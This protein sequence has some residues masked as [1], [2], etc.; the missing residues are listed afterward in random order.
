MAK[1]LFKVKSNTT[2]FHWEGQ[3]SKFGRK[4]KYFSSA[5]EAARGLHYTQ[6]RP[7]LGTTYKSYTDFINDLV[8]EELHPDYYTKIQSFPATDAIEAYK[9]QTSI[10]GKYGYTFLCTWLKIASKPEYQG[11]KYLI[12]I[13]D[14]YVEFRERLKG[15]GYSSRAYKKLGEWILVFDDDVA[16]RIKLIDGYDQFINVDTFIVDLMQE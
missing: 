10:I 4:G 3:G 5:I 14:D 15:L 9:L 2:G 8:I 13:T 11:G 7:G 16:M 6:I 12:R 1:R